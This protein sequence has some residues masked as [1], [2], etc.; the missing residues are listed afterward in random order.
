MTRK[1]LNVNPLL[2]PKHKFS[3]ISN[4]PSLTLQL[5]IQKKVSLAH[6]GLLWPTHEIAILVEINDGAVRSENFAKKIF[7]L[8]AQVV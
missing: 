6:V 1:V 2:I 3:H 7:L 5:L 8:G 4:Y